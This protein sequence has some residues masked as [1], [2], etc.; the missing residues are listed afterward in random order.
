[1]YRGVDLG[2]GGYSY[3]E[4]GIYTDVALID[5][6]S[7]HPSSMVA[8]NYFGKYTQRFKDI[9]DARIAIKNKNFDKARSMFDGALAKYLEDETQ[10]DGLAQALKIA[11]NSVYGLTAASFENPFHDKRNVN[12]IVALRG[13]L[14]MKTLLDELQAMG[15]KVVHLK[16]DSMKIPNATPDILQ[17]CMDFAKKYGY[18]FAH[19][20]TYDRMCLIDKAQY[21][22]A[23]KDPE[24]CNEMYGYIPSDNAKHFRK[25]THPWTTTG[26]AF[27]HPYIFKTLFSGEEWVFKDMCETKSVRDAAI[28]LDMNETLPDV[29][30]YEKEMERREFNENHP[31][32]KPMKLNSDYTDISDEELKGLIADGHDYQFVGRVGSFFPVRKGTG[33]G[34][35]LAKRNG[36]YSSVSGAK[37]YRWLEAEVAEEL[38]KQDEYDSEYF[39]KLVDD[40]ISAVNNFGNF[41]R[42]IDT[43]K[44]YILEEAELP[45]EGLPA[46][47][48]CGDRKYNSCVE[49]RHFMNDSCDAGYDLK[50]SVQIGRG[51]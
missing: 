32:K 31:D 11:I 43:S 16:V 2:F 9:L 29:S 50:D 18:S 47:V 15:V 3:S 42:F 19:E 28:Y 21:V 24:L 33:G 10:A 1:M 27:Q 22:A 37:G 44:N 8:M 30:L 39:D 36:K 45:W 7:M 20:A 25:H 12:N 26:D 17:Y 48:P 41:D 49:C 14:F 46:V 4:P 35:L 40:A 38:G 5:I 23:Y 13:A 34:L 6:Q 51:G